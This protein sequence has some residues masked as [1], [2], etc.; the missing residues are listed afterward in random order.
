[1]TSPIAA[2]LYRHL[3]QQG[4]EC[5]A[6]A[7]GSAVLL[8]LGGHQV[9]SLNRTGAFLVQALLQHGGD[10]AE[11]TRRLAERYAVTPEQAASDVDAFLGDLAVTLQCPA[12]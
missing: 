7:D 8:D 9:V 1:M 10:P 5:T 6:L 11:L 4:I 12:D 3:Q 2:R